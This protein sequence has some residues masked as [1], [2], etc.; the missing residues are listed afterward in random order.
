MKKSVSFMMSALLGLTLLAG[1][2]TKSAAKDITIAFLPNEKTPERSEE[3]FNMLKDEVQ[4][5]L[6]DGYNVKI[7]VLDEYA[8]VTEAM[9]S[10]TAQI[11]WESGATFATTYM[12]NDK[13]LPLVSYGPNG[14][15][16]KS[17]YNAYIAT[18]VSHKADFE[19]KSR[20][21]KLA[22]L[23]GKSFSFVSASST[24]GCLVPTQSLWEIF[25]VD[26][27]KDVTTKEQINVKNTADGGV[28]S[29]VQYGGSHPGSVT[30]IAQDKVYA[31]AYCCNYGEEY[32]DDLYIVDQQ[33]VPNG[34]LWVNTEALGADAVQKLTDHFVNLTA[35]NAVNKDFFSKDKGFFFEVE[36]DPSNYKFFKTDVSNYQFIIDMAKSSN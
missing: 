15:A 16:E 17:G 2:S 30:L 35:D 11:A 27:S 7:A 6:G 24:S 29:D 36:D 34:P 18:N 19:G 28:F 33:F 32:K 1:C 21:E 14:D 10:G 9:L 22:L 3:A 23:K 20:E 5:A 25:G 31:G 13:V 12:K 8:A 4:A 26:G